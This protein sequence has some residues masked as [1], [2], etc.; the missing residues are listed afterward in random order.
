[1]YFKED[2]LVLLRS[3]VL[4]W[5]A[6]VARAELV[7]VVRGGK[8]SHTWSTWR[9]SRGIEALIPEKRARSEDIKA[10]NT[11]VL[12]ILF[13]LTLQNVCLLYWPFCFVGFNFS[14]LASE[15]YVSLIWFLLLNIFKGC[16][17]TPLTVSHW[18]WFIFGI[19]SV[20]VAVCFS[21]VLS[22]S[23]TYLIASFFFFFPWNLFISTSPSFVSHL[24]PVGCNSEP[25]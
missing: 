21:P 3:L 4:Y 17:S 12:C 5:A 15:L 16:K 22:D 10:T 24:A 8:M 23:V 7:E 18:V 20:S 25:W 13:S 14:F 19:V 2:Q 11:C 9:V 1:M 6:T